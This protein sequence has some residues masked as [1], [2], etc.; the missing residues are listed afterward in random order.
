MMRRFYALLLAIV[1]VIGVQGKVFSVDGIRY[2]TD[3]WMDGLKGHLLDVEDG[4]GFAIV[5]GL[6]DNSNISELTIPETVYYEGKPLIVKYIDGHAFANCEDLTSVTIGSQIEHIGYRAFYG[7]SN[8]SKFNIPSS[9]IDIES[10]VFEGTAWYNNQP[11]ELVYK[12]NVLLGRKTLFIEGHV[13][14]ADGTRVIA[15]RVFMYC[16]NMTSVNIPNTVVSIGESAFYQAGIAELTIPNSVTNIFSNAFY[17]CENLNKI[18]S[19]IEPPFDLGDTVFKGTKFFATLFVPAGTKAKYEAT[20]G[21]K[22]FKNIVEMEPIKVG[23]TFT[24][25]GITYKV[26]STS[27]MEV[28]VGTGEDTKTAINKDAEGSL[29]IPAS[30]VG[31]DGNKYSV[32]TIGRSAFYEC[33]KITDIDIPNSVISIGSYAF[34]RCI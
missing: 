5:L 19:L 24:T 18:I 2:G 11:D 32:T 28:Q 15:G 13:D 14:I 1:A 7:C 33:S 16:Q 31:T 9:V 34:P 17:Y 26:T 6:E 10:Q 27:P 30:V 25:N 21:W 23:D 4:S 20:E 22:E 12:D 29:K 8:L 3:G